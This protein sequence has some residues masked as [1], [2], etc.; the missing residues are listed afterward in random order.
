MNNSFNNKKTTTLLVITIIFLLVLVVGATYAYF[1]VGGNTGINADVSVT[2]Y[3]L[4]TLSFEV[5]SQV[6]FNL[7][8]ESFASGTGNKTGSTY[9]KVLLTA[10]NKTNTATMN[11][12][13]YLNISNNTFTYTQNTSTPEILMTIT[14]GSGTAVTSIEGLTHKTVTDGK[15]VEVSG[16]D[17]TNKTGLIPLFANR[18]IT[19]SPNAEEKWNVTITYINYNADQSANAGKSI[20][21]NLLIRKDSM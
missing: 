8:Q 10:N 17:I 16:F 19:A 15:G 9:A 5:G 6:S 12:Y 13:L 21:A 4:D 18:S 11:Y 20:S 2:T 3:T 1:V 14:N 7:D